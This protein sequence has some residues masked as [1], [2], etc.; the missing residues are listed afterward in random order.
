MVRRFAK[1]TGYRDFRR[2]LHSTI[3][4]GDHTGLPD[5]RGGQGGELSTFFLGP[6]GENGELFG[7]LVQM[8]V[9]AAVT[10]RRF[11]HAE[12]PPHITE[13]TK[14][15]REYLAGVETLRYKYNVL[16]QKLAQYTTP[17]FSLRYQ[18]HM[19][20]DNTIPGMLGFFA[21]MMHN[22]NNV[23]VQ[24]STL[25]TF[26]EMAVGEDLCEML[27]FGNRPEPWAHLTADGTVANLEATWAAR[28]LKYLPAAI[29]WALLNDDSYAAAGGVSVGLPCGGSKPLV[30]LG[31]WQLLNLE[32]DEILQLPGKIAVHWGKDRTEGIEVREAAVW[33]DLLGKYSLNS[34]GWLNVYNTYLNGFERLP[35]IVTPSTKHYSWP[36][37]VAVLGPGSRDGLVD[38]E[39]DERARMNPRA[40]RKVLQDLLDRKRPVLLAVA[41]MGSTEESAVD[42][43]GEVLE[44]RKEF[45]AKG[46]EF[47]LHADA[48]WGGYFLSTLRKDFDAQ[49]LRFNQEDEALPP[50][51][52]DPFITDD[53][54]V[55]L[56]KYTKAQMKRIRHCDS[57]TIDP[58]KCGY[59]QY[60]AGAICYRNSEYK[61]LLT[62]GAP[63]IGMPGTEPTVGIY[64][65]EGSRPGASAAGVFLSHAVIRPSVSGYGKLL[66]RALVNARLFYL[67]LLTL[68][69]PGDPF[70]V[71]PL[72]LPPEGFSHFAAAEYAGMLLGKIRQKGLE[73]VLEEDGEFF[74]ELGPDQNIVDY[75]FNIQRRDGAVE[76]DLATVNKLNQ[77]LYDRLHVKPGTDSNGYD[78]LI[79]QTQMSTDDYGETF[80]TAYLERLGVK[81][82]ASRPLQVNVNRSVI[83]DPWSG[84]TQ[85]GNGE[86]FDLIFEVLRK[87]V[88]QIIGQMHSAQVE[89]KAA[90][91]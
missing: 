29:R 77:A 38:V 12:D 47:S 59:I 72:A 3:A 40:L 60:P 48:A 56:S 8:A 36:K 1:S 62:F 13:E 67:H 50:E 52:R 39:V 10:Q 64:G 14:H 43:L 90:H 57:V 4:V 30:S 69:R 80:I 79:S 7:E 28:E 83:M 85:A 51:D 44:I 11:F 32:M 46:L 75:T 37:A 41:V 89:K 68:A 33:S 19:L 55:R 66:N 18:G 27:G 5:I 35:V 78:F 58:H 15:S 74:N 31:T 2:G 17:Y 63:V 20:R 71:V 84:E 54:R 81:L 87:T 26:L 21:T 88:L 6:K 25:T 70:L 82:P 73:T 9:D 16:L 22:P 23:T 24:A 45:R 91:V 65:V 49:P 34:A 42:P 76:T 61:N 53:R 86:F